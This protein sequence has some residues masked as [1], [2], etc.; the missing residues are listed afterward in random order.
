MPS[1]VIGEPKLSPSAREAGSKGESCVEGLPA[2][3]PCALMLSGE[4]NSSAIGD[5]AGTPQCALGV[6]GDSGVVVGIRKVSSSGVLLS[7]LHSELSPEAGS[8]MALRSGVEGQLNELPS[9]DGTPC[10]AATQAISE[11]GAA[12]SGLEQ[13]ENGCSEIVWR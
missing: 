9:V 12:R 3:D 8:L 1:A 6:M 5:M 10:H 2:T 11:F 4:G 13:A 7:V